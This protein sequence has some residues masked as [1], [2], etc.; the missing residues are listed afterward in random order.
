[1]AHH[2][3]L[4][5]LWL[6]LAASS[7]S[8][9]TIYTSSVRKPATKE[10]AHAFW[11]RASSQLTGGLQHKAILTSDSS[12]PPLPD[13]GGMRRVAM[14]ITGGA[15]SI[16][17]PQFGIPE[18][19]VKHAVGGLS[20]NVTHAYYVLDTAFIPYKTKKRSLH[21]VADKVAWSVDWTQVCLS[22]RARALGTT[23][24]TASYLQLGRV[25][26]ILEPK[27]LQTVRSQ[28]DRVCSRSYLQYVKLARCLELIYETE[29]LEGWRYDFILR[30]RPDT[31]LLS[32]L[33]S[34]HKLKR[35]IYTPRCVLRCAA[36]ELRCSLNSRRRALA[37]LASGCPFSGM[38]PTTSSSWP[39][40]P[41]R[42]PLSA[43]RA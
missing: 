4:L 9:E 26:S 33:P 24:L 32:P 3:L 18:S 39:T 17:L 25:F 20:A 38:W 23:G 15:R 34:V 30:L 27:A 13:R 21:S 7:F 6:P 11:Q 19:W 40:D 37:G 2:V 28:S 42:K 22:A 41:S 10:E 31:Q 29:L 1:M 14:C 36:H 5:L 35:A 16:A 43:Q 8:A 12:L